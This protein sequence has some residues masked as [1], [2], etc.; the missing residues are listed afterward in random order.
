MV[1][2]KAYK[3]NPDKVSA[4]AQIIFHRVDE[5]CLTDETR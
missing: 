5:P 2:E 1:A 4:K 3:S